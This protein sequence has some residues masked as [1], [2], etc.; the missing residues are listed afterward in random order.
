MSTP[1]VRTRPPKGVIL[2]PGRSLARY[3]GLQSYLPVSA[4]DR[5]GRVPAIQRAS[6][7]WSSSTGSDSTQFNAPMVWYDSI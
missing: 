2:P 6:L 3:A 4:H 7:R 1:S 5:V